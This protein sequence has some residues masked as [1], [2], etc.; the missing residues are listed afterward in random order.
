MRK[1]KTRTSFFKTCDCVYFYPKFPLPAAV[2]PKGSPCPGSP[3][4]Q[5]A[6]RRPRHLLDQFVVALKGN[7]RAQHPHKTPGD[8][9]LDVKESRILVW[10]IPVPNFKGFKLED[11]MYKSIQRKSIGNIR[12]C[13]QLSRCCLEDSTHST[14]EHGLPRAIGSPL[15]PMCPGRAL[16]DCSLEFRQ[17]H[18]F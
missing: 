8:F 11:R 3:T 14:A 5:W 6:P 2:M 18:Y 7:F 9:T 17:L 16:G 13:P 4:H 1:A 12:E 10:W 15:H